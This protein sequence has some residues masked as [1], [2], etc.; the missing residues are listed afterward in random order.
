MKNPITIRQ[1]NEKAILVEWQQKIDDAILEDIIRLK[2]SIWQSS[3]HEVED[4]IPGYASLMVVYKEKIDFDSVVTAI[5]KNHDAV[6]LTDDIEYKEWHIPVCYDREF[7]DDIDT[8]LDKKNINFETA[9]KLH[10]SVKYR[11]FAIGFLPGFLYLGGLNEDLHIPRKEVPSLHVAKGSV[12][13][14]GSQTGIYPINSPGGWY[15]I[16]RTPLSIFDLEKNPPSPIKQGDY[17]IFYPVGIDKYKI[18]NAHD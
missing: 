7:A 3:N 6:S 1:A 9:I 8:F 12:A 16:G 14:G 2:Q 18:F 5:K 11:V 13:I 17:I 4:I 10:T 15:V